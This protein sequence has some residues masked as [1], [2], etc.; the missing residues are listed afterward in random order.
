LNT[1]TPEHDDGDSLVW[2]GVG[3]SIIGLSLPTFLALCIAISVSLYPNPWAYVLFP[4][5]VIA[6]AC[7]VA[8]VIL[9]FVKRQRVSRVVYWRAWAVLALAVL[10]GVSTLIL[11]YARF[12]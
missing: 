5:A 12:S 3:A 7:F 11:I 4:L 6:P 10:A 1:I 9:L 8:A 2:S